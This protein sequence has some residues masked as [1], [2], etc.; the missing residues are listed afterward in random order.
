MRSRS[1]GSE[2][3]ERLTAATALVLT[4]LLAIEGV[5][6][7]FL[8]PLLS[9]HVFVGLLLV[10]PVALKLGSTGYRFLRYYQ[11]RP[12]YVAKGPPAPLMR[13]VVAPVLVV[14]TVAVLASGIA[15]IAFG[16]RGGLVLGVH[17]GSFVVWIG[18]MAVHF[19]VYVRRLPRLLGSRRFRQGA[20]LRAVAVAATLV[21]GAALGAAL[22]PLARP[23]LR[24]H[25]DGRREHREAVV[26]RRPLRLP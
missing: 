26:D 3:N 24:A 15:L 16:Q 18:A 20:G 25:D 1:G 4:L 5:T 19:L 22:V 17:K 9:V 2:G 14:S 7:L 8:R 10:P 23:W 21:A 6:I 11:R 12:E 13:F